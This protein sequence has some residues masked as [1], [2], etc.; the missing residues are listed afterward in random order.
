MTTVAFDGVHLVSDTLG[1]D[2]WGFRHLE[3]EKIQKSEDGS[4]CFGAAGGTDAIVSWVKQIRGM[5]LNEVLEYGFP[6]FDENNNNNAILLCSRR[7]GHT[8]IWTLTGRTFHKVH[9]KFHAIGS[10]RDY[11]VAAM[12]LGK[13]AEEAVKIAA[14]FNNNTNDITHSIK[15]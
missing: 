15:L 10:G 4:F 2:P 9:R 8:E 3:V 13:S 5:S 1:V 14:E 7:D 11:A 6:E 12:Y